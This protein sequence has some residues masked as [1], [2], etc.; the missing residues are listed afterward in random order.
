MLSLWFPGGRISVLP[1]V[2]GSLRWGGLAALRRR[3][4]AI[5]L[6]TVQMERSLSELP[7]GGYLFG[8]P[9]STAG[10]RVAVLPET[11][12]PCQALST[13]CGFWPGPLLGGPAWT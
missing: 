1:V 8:P 9:K 7:G 2:F 13:G 6:G 11:D 12:D 5:Q 4:V 3:D 10:R